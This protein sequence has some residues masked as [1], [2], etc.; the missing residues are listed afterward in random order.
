MNSREW[1][2][3]FRQNRRDRL[4]IVWETAA[5]LRRELPAVLGPSLAK[6]QLGESSAGLHLRAAAA[7]TGDRDY[8][9]AIELFIAEEADHA[10]LLARVLERL[11][12]PTLRRH[13]AD[14]CCRRL[15]RAAGLYSEL[16]VLLA[17][18]VILLRYYGAV[19]RGA[20]HPVVEA[21]CE[22]ILHDQK[23][24]VRFH[25]ET[26][27]HRLAGHRWA[28]GLFC[29]ALTAVFT[30]GSLVVA[31]D[32]RRALAAVGCPPREFLA[33]AWRNFRAARDAV[34]FGRAF[35]LDTA[36]QIVGMETKPLAER[37][38]QWMRLT[39]HAR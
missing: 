22:Q 12:T 28:R 19:R 4:P 35:A 6:F 14:E 33:G 16:A 3:Y 7:R 10:R 11:E 29:Y 38:R 9:A 37:L 25:C 15:R 31:W 24:H 23:F 21:V 36:D 18:E 8:A 1:L 2:A 32:H 30:L 39:P 17:A 26:L 5:P 20:G 13:W 34:Y 27:H